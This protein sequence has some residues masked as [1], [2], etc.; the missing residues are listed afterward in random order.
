MCVCERERERERGNLSGRSSEDRGGL[1]L[2]ESNRDAVEALLVEIPEVD[3]GGSVPGHQV[4]RQ[5]G[6]GRRVVCGGGGGG[7][8]G[9]VLEGNPFHFVFG[10]DGAPL[11]YIPIVH[12]EVEPH[13]CLLALS[14]LLQCFCIKY[15]SV[16]EHLSNDNYVV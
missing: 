9:V 1:G 6:G 10:C 5:C 13:F 11:L 7:E 2:A 8:D 3:S 14:S 16:Q 12:V 15:L 4:S